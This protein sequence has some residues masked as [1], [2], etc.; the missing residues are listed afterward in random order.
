MQEKLRQIHSR[1]S[2]KKERVIKTEVSRIE[3]TKTKRRTIERKERKRI[4]T[5]ISK[6]HLS[7]RREEINKISKWEE[8][9]R[10]KIKI[11]R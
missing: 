4:A 7:K 8:R 10:L 5:K 6:E 3:E 11:I 9:K 2:I 1:P